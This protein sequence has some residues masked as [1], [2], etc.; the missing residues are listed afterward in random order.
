LTLIAGL[1]ALAL[2]ALA[3]VVQHAPG[4]PPPET[5]GMKAWRLTVVLASRCPP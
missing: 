3:M 4:M 1:W 2:G 5:A